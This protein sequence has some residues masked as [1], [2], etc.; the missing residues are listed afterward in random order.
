[1]QNYPVSG[2]F[3]IL[4]TQ[5]ALHLLKQISPFGLPRLKMDQVNPFSEG[6]LRTTQKNGNSS[7]ILGQTLTF[8]GMLSSASL[9]AKSGR[10]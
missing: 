2:L 10:E 6:I 1:M 7:I 3:W 8:K 9:A 5:K 4:R